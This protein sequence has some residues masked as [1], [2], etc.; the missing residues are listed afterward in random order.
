[1]SKKLKDMSSDELNRALSEVS[2]KRSQ[3]VYK[4]PILWAELYE[5]SM[6]IDEEVLRRIKVGGISPK[7]ANE[8]GIEL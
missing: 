4:N 2:S 7:I 5:L 8:F 1:M 3:N 6:L